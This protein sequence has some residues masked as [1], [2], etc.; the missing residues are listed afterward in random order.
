METSN[1]PRLG[2]EDTGKC[3]IDLRQSIRLGA[4]GNDHRSAAELGRCAVGLG[5][6]HAVLV[7]EGSRSL[8][9][10]DVKDAQHS[11]GVLVG[12]E[13]DPRRFPEQKR[14]GQLGN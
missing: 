14:D 11:H 2:I 13:G 4:G 12:V 9:D 6:L 10:L 7:H 8:Q 5:E 1:R 3:E